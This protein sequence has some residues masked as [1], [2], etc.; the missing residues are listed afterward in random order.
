MSMILLMVLGLTGV[1]CGQDEV[2]LEHFQTGHLYSIVNQWSEIF[3]SPDLLIT[4]WKKMVEEEGSEML[5]QDSCF[6]EFIQILRAS[7]N[8]DTAAV[9]YFDSWGKPGSAI[10]QGNINFWGYYDECINL[11][12]TAIG[13]TG[14]CR[15]K[16]L[17]TSNISKQSLPLEV[18]MCYPSQCSP[19]SF[20]SSVISRLLTLVNNQLVSRQHLF[21]ASIQFTVDP[22]HAPFCPWRDL[23][24]DAGTIAVLVVCVLL[25]ALVLAGTL[26]DGVTWYYEEWWV[27]P[28]STLSSDND[29]SPTDNGQPSGYSTIINDEDSEENTSEGT[30]DKSKDNKICRTNCDPF[31]IIKDFLQCFSLCKNLPVILA[32]GQPEGA[33]T[34]LNGIRVIGMFWIILGHSLIFGIKTQVGDNPVYAM[35][36]TYTRFT[37]Q[38][39]SNAFL[40]VDNF[41]LLSGMLITYLVLREMDR[42]KGKIPLVFFYLHRYVRISPLYYFLLFLWFKVVPHIGHGPN[43]HYTDRHNCEQYWWTNVLYINNFHPR[44]NHICYLV[45][46]YLAVDTQLFIFAPIFLYLLYHY[47]R[48]GVAAIFVA[49]CATWTTTGIIA[50]VNEYKANAIIESF[51]GYA[52]TGVLDYPDSRTDIY[53]KPYCRASAYLIGM[54]LGFVLHK[55]WEPPKGLHIRIPFYLVMWILAGVLC[56]TPVY[57]LY[58]DFNGHELSDFENIIYYMFSATGYCLGLSC[59]IYACHNNYGFIINTILSWK[60]WVPLSR[61]TFAVYLIHVPLYTFYFATM[62]SRIAQTDYMIMLAVTAN[63]GLS[64]SIGLAI[65]A[66]VEYP[67]AYLVLFVYKIFGFDFEKERQNQKQTKARATN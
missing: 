50:G 32:T 30:A 56:I 47:W 67:F 44:Y 40:A 28:S 41:L 2:S 15:F 22:V 36:H 45:S 1:V 7:L 60:L 6:I 49:L 8:N 24:Y 48:V 33:I 4:M 55:K 29:F 13:K 39:I 23:D 43:W 20:S 17:A 64:Y 9:K 59:V 61:L 65:A 46:W 54:L 35:R 11:K 5:D 58:R 51:G 12:D 27:K 10:I 26:V 63:I 66:L 31:N 62:Q 19:S 14:Y 37:F 57:G 34:C 16:I 3:S 52:G 18:G 38:V 42:R 25:V 53:E 21:P